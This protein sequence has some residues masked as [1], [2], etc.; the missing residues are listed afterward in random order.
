MVFVELGLP[1]PELGLPAEGH[2]AALFPAL[3]T[4]TDL[5][6]SLTPPKLHPLL[7]LRRGQGWHTR[8]LA[9]L[10][11]PRRLPADGRSISD[12]QGPLGSP[13]ALCLLPPIPTY[14]GGDTHRCCFRFLGLP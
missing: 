12:S 1:L 8:M 5:A 14:A 11:W 3:V 7:P 2:P 9:H 10:A 6:S 13:R 4:L